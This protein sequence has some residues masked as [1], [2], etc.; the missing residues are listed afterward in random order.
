MSRAL[1]DMDLLVNG[2][3][4]FVRGPFHLLAKEIESPARGKSVS[5]ADNGLNFSIGPYSLAAWISS[6]HTVEILI[7]YRGVWGL[8][9][10]HAS[11]LPFPYI[12]DT[13]EIGCFVR[14]DRGKR[15]L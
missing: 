5:H 14:T 15:D 7:L 10:I 3:I 8:L 2:F 11:F 6:N 9:G 13:Q 4:A 1:Q 12:P